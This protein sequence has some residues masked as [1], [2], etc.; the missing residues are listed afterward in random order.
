MKKQVSKIVLA[1][2]VTASMLGATAVNAAPV[3]K[4][5]KHTKHVK[6]AAKLRL[7]SNDVECNSDGSAGQVFRL[8]G[9][10]VYSGDSVPNSALCQ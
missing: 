1:L 9:V 10:K 5:A 8:F 4:A 6:H 2:A 3:A 7:W